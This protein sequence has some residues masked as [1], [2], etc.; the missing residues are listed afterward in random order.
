MEA[1]ENSTKLYRKDKLAERKY[2]QRKLQCKRVLRKMVP[3]QQTVIKSQTS[4]RVLSNT[5]LQKPLI[6]REIEN[7]HQHDF[8]DIIDGR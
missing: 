7:R 8:P 5:T 6:V 3:L 2:A 4:K 1:A